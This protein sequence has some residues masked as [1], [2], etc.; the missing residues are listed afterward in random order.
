M[1]NNWRN[2]GLTLILSC[3]MDVHLSQSIDASLQLFKMSLLICSVQMNDIIA[4]V[5][6][7]LICDTIYDKFLCSGSKSHRICMCKELYQNTIGRHTC[8]GK[9][10]LLWTVDVTVCYLRLWFF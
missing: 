3:P 5:C 2:S 9:V 6:V 10:L 1:C 4:F 8:Y 7:H